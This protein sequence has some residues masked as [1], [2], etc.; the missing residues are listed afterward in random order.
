MYHELS[1]VVHNDRANYWEPEIDGEKLEH[2]NYLTPHKI[3]IET[4]ATQEA[5]NKLRQDKNME[6]PTINEIQDPSMMPKAGLDS[7]DTASTSIRAE[8]SR[9][10][11]SV[12]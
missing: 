3:E 8:L 6:V 4:R 2:K 7:I 5:W 11:N 1:H 12:E 9:E 10:F